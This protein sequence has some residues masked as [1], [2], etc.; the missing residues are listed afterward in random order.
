M[1]W[2]PNP[3]LWGDHTPDINQTKNNIFCNWHKAWDPILM[4]IIRVANEKYIIF[5]LVAK[6]VAPITHDEPLEVVYVT[7]RG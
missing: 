1:H 4:I 3:N 5:A 6:E 2:S 7:S